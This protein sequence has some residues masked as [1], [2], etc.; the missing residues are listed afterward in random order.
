M[1]IEILVTASIVII[2]WLVAHLLTR[3]R[4]RI[5]KRQDKRTEYLINAYRKLESSANRD[6]TREMANNIESAIADIQLF[7]NEKQINFA[8]IFSKSLA[9]KGPAS[10]DNLLIQLREDLRKELKLSKVPREISYLRI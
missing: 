8:N 5:G 1:N 4:E 10:L 6:A 3:H 9:E 2:G 7:G